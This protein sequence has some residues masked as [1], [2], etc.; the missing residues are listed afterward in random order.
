MNIRTILISTILWTAIIQPSAAGTLVAGV[1]ETARSFLLTDANEAFAFIDFDFQLRE[2]SNSPSDEGWLDG[3]FAPEGSYQLAAWP[4]SG[5]DRFDHFSVRWRGVWNPGKGTYQLRL[6]S[7]GEAV[8]F[9]GGGETLV[10]RDT[11]SGATTTLELDERPYELRLDYSHLTGD[12]MVF[13]EWCRPGEVWVPL[14]PLSKRIEEREGWIGTY[15]LGS[16]FESEQFQRTDARIIWNWGEWGPLNRLEDL[17]TSTLEWSHHDGNL[18]GA[19]SSNREGALH[20]QIKPPP[21]S[22]DTR[23]DFARTSLVIASSSMVEVHIQFDQPG[24]WDGD[25]ICFDLPSDRPLSFWETGKTIHNGGQVEAAIRGQRDRYAADRQRLEGSM[26]HLDRVLCRSGRWWARVLLDRIAYV[27]NESER[28]P[29]NLEDETLSKLGSSLVSWSQIFAPEIHEELSNG[30]SDTSTKGLDSLIGPVSSDERTNDTLLSPYPERTVAWKVATL[31]DGLFEWSQA[32]HQFEE[33]MGLGD[34]GTIDFRK[35]KAGRELKVK[36]L[37]F[38]EQRL[39]FDSTAS[40]FRIQNQ[41]GCFLEFSGSV[42]V[43]G[44]QINGRGEWEAEIESSQQVLLET[45]P[46][47]RISGATWEGEPLLLTGRGS[48]RQT[49]F[50]PGRKGTLCLIPSRE[51]RGIPKE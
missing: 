25:S 50:L 42:S 4:I 38:G 48:E 16:H 43:Q 31:A 14:V 7:D 21:K 10:S 28:P 8:L 13:L 29:S 47:S 22:T 19:F 18:M 24:L 45:G 20:I 35:V 9:V 27:P 49:G 2:P 17:P 5:P 33:S 11:R 23:I 37:P 34:S 15:Y 40:R 46:N 3:V 30:F 6:R 44:F 32:Y 26:A 36:N 12:S 39:S 51:T 1:G 41:E